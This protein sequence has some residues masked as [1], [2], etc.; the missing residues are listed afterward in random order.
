MDGLETNR[1]NQFKVCTT[2]QRTV[3][4][5]MFAFGDCAAC[6]RGDGT[7]ALVPP[8]AQ[9]AHR[10]AAL[11]AKSLAARLDGKAP[12]TYRYPDFGSLV[13]LSPTAA[14]Y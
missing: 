13:S 10:Q 12:L 14:T 7:D 4:E 2:L 1:L 5:N 8:R 9:A 6:P 3:D 11:L